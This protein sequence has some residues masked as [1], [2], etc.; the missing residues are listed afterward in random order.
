M[1]PREH[2]PT[3]DRNHQELQAC[4]GHPHPA[5]TEITRRQDVAR[6]IRP[7]PSLCRWIVFGVA[8]GTSPRDSRTPLISSELD[9]DG[10]EE[11]E[12]NQ[13]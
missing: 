13:K 4:A 11:N 7:A 2:G 3:I 5:F 6:D 9:D 12:P 8:P 10:G 1:A